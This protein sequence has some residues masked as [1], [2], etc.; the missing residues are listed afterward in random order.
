MT[1]H[2]P[3]RFRS[4]RLHDEAWHE[5][6]MESLLWLAEKLVRRPSIPCHLEYI[7]HTQPVYLPADSSV[8]DEDHRWMRNMCAKENREVPPELSLQEV[9]SHAVLAH[10]RVLAAFPNCLSG[11]LRDELH[12]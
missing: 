3:V 10:W 8:A 11:D 9:N 2:L 12:R 1:K 5:K 6:R 7:R 4:V